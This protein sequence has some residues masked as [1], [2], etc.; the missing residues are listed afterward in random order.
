MSDF[1][2]ALLI[3]VKKGEVSSELIDAKREV[4]RVKRLL[5]GGLRR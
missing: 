1:Y 3:G 2:L 4:L 5:R